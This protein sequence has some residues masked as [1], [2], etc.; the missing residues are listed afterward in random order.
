MSNHYHCLF[1]FS[2]LAMACFTASSF[3]MSRDAVASSKSRM[4]L[5]SGWRGLLKF[6]DAHRQREDFHSRQSAYRIP[7]AILRMKLSQLASRQ[8]AS[9]SASVALGRACR[10][11]SRMVSS[12]R[13]TSWSTIETCSRTRSAATWLMGLPPIEIVPP[14]AS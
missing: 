5:F 3:S 12:K 9:I 11:L 10:I 6:A 4:G 8:A 1:F 7:F 14:V 2:R 13:N